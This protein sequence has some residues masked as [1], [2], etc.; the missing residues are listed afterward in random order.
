[1]SENVNRKPEGYDRWS[2]KVQALYDLSQHPQFGQS[3]L[4]ALGKILSA[5][6]PINEWLDAFAALHEVA[7]PESK[8]EGTRRTERLRKHGQWI[9]PLLLRRTGSQDEVL[10]LAMGLVPQAR[11]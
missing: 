3:A 4:E 6:G 2:H 10:K 11:A 1:M 9:W 5:R 7:Y 8:E